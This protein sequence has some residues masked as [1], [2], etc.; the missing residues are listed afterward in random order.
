M[1]I[2]YNSSKIYKICDKD[3]FYFIDRTTDT[4]LS[5]RLIFLRKS[6]EKYVKD[7]TSKFHPYFKILEKGE[8]NTSLIENFKCENIKE[9]KNRLE[10]IINL[11]ENK[12]EFCLNHINF[13]IKRTIPKIKCDVCNVQISKNQI[14]RHVK[15]NF[16]KKFL[17]VQS[18]N[19][20][21]QK[22]IIIFKE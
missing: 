20:T 12:N 5:K 13:E 17:E 7:N 14:N 1:K 3:G 18:C 2:K 16:H 10:E 21:D 22:P 11:D 6:Y 4:Y 19:E 15:G 8:Y 9:L